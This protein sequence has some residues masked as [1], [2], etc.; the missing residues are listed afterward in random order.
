MTDY[1]APELRELIPNAQQEMVISW[2]VEAVF[3]A[4][5]VFWNTG[6]GSGKSTLRAMIAQA[7]LDTDMHESLYEVRPKDA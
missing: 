4:A 2:V 3:N 5:P 7:I 6:R 1:V